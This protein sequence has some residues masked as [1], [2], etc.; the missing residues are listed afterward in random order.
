MKQVE[1]LPKLKNLK[2]VT[3]DSWV[4]K[5]Q[6]IDA[7][8]AFIMKSCKKFDYDLKTPHILFS[9]HG[10]PKSY[11]EDGDPYQEQMETCVNLIMEELK[12]NGF[13][14]EFTLAY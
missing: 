6:Y 13:Q 9:A 2:S 7:Q 14:N 4:D 5:K 1:N 3:I 8:A 11:I 10:V 12:A